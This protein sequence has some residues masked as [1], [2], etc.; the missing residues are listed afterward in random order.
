MLTNILDVHF[1]LP[2][3]LHIKFGFNFLHWNLVDT[4]III[5]HVFRR[6]SI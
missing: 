1:C 3:L 5:N 4:Q 6:A 2:C